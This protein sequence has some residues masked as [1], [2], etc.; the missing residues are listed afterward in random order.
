VLTTPHRKKFL[1]YETDKEA[2]DLD[3]FFGTAPATEKG[4]E[5]W[6]ME[7]KENSRSGMGGGAWTGLSWRRI[8]TD[9]GL[10]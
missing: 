10:L 9:G 2:S 4:R 3:R 7:C 6:N 8:G 1:C 5:F